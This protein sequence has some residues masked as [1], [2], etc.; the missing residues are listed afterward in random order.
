MI[1]TI[2]NYFRGYLLV[3]ITGNALERFI[4]QLVENNI[5]LWNIKKIKTGH[6]QARM[7]AQDFNRLRPILRK[8]MCRVRIVKKQG[9]LF[10]LR[11]IFI[12]FYLLLGLVIFIVLLWLLSSLIWY[13]DIEG[14]E[15]IE[16][17]C[18]LQLLKH[19]GIYAGSYKRRI[20]LREAERMILLSEPGISWINMELRGTILKV[21]IIEK[22]KISEDDFNYIAA[23]KDGIINEI[24][25]MRGRAVVNEGDTVNS[26]QKLI[27][28]AG[29][30][31][32][33]VRGIVNAVVWYNA[34]GEARLHCREAVPGERKKFV[35]IIRVGKFSRTLLSQPSFTSFEP[36]IKTLFAIKWR[37]YSF[38]IEII[39]KEFTEIKYMNYERSRKTAL[40][41]AKNR[42]IDE[43]LSGLDSKAVILDTRA[44]IAAA[45]ENRVRVRVWL[46]TEENIA[47]HVSE[48]KEDFSE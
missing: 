10:L 48:N 6:Y 24:I 18:I 21:K 28:S 40:F 13:I 9:F 12:N 30:D 36:E 16:Q 3:E 25:V 45:E 26:G 35:P 22:K 15:E 19:Q 31:T 46:K 7:R 41:L 29:K 8:R 44:E 20:D 37:N 38:P 34:V 43:I 33:P 5:I 2:I 47:Q 11:K 17:E 23:A 32:G 1:R 39:I 42:A 14:L 27:V 4:S